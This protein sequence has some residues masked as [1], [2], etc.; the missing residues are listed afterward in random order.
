MEKY[1][2]PWHL[3]SKPDFITL[4]PRGDYGGAVYDISCDNDEHTFERTFSNIMCCFGG[5]SCEKRFYGV[6]GSWGI[7]SDMAMA[8]NAATQAA[9]IMGQ[10]HFFG[11][12]SLEGAMFLGDD[13]KQ[14]INADIQ[15][16]LNNTQ[17]AS[18]LIADT[19]ADFIM[20]WTEKY[21]NKVGTGEC[22][23]LGETFEKDLE[24]WIARQPESVKKDLETAETMVLDLIKAAKNGKMS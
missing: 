4:D 21:Y 1:G 16:M 6:D 2:K 14:K 17:A 9:A 8:T 15:V 19:Y 3:G 18:D 24:D 12:K 5:T 10:G 20:E 13:D 11:K 7:T 22:L 23:I